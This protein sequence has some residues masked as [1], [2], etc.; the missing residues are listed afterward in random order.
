[1]GGKEDNIRGRHFIDA[2]TINVISYMNQL[3]LCRITGLLSFL[4]TYAQVPKIHLSAL[5]SIHQSMTKSIFDDGSRKSIGGMFEER[6][7]WNGHRV[8]QC[9]SRTVHDI[10]RCCKRQFRQAS[11][12]LPDM[13]LPP[14]Y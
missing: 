4:G 7:G 9:I 2:E 3:S 6:L 14:Y 12:S 8:M 5:P 10:C 1:M 11:R 13:F